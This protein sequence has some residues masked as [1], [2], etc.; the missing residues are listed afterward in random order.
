MNIAEKVN[1]TTVWTPSKNAVACEVE[2]EMV[3]LNLQSGTYFGLNGVGTEIWNQLAQQKTFDEIQQHL[4]ARYRVA[5]ERCE[6]E[7]LALLTKLTERGLVR[8][9]SDETSA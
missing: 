9:G 6:A 3:L 7:V 8:T 5:P 1:G 2:G 4:L